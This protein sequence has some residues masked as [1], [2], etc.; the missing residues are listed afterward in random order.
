MK[1]IFFI[2][3]SKAIER[4]EIWDSMDDLLKIEKPINAEKGQKHLLMRDNPICVFLMTIQGT[5]ISAK[6]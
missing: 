4:I 2:F 5:E 6:S 1:F 3:T